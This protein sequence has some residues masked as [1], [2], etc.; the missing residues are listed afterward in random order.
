MQEPSLHVRHMAHMQNHPLPINGE[1]SVVTGIEEIKIEEV[2]CM[3][4][5]K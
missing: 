5:T 1:G 4:S 3:I 2:Y